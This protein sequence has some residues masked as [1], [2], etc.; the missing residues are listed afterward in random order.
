MDAVCPCVQ[1][2]HRETSFDRQTSDDL[3]LNPIVSAARTERST[4]FFDMLQPAKSR[5]EMLTGLT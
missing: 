2:T 5:D 3:S 4:F 1:L